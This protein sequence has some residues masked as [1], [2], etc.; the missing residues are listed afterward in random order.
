MPPN[1]YKS[2]WTPEITEWCR[3]L[4]FKGGMF[5]A[6]IAAEL[7]PGFNKNQVI[8]KIHRMGW[9]K[10]PDSPY[11]R[12]WGIKDIR[13]RQSAPRPKRNGGAVISALKSIDKSPPKPKWSPKMP[14]ADAPKF[15]ITEPVELTMDDIVSPLEQRVTIWELTD[16]T[17]RWPYGSAETEIFFCGALP[18][19]GLPYC[20]DHCR[21]AYQVPR[22]R[23]QRRVDA[24]RAARMRA[25]KG[26][27]EAA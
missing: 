27:T 12:K 19:E 3:A 18:I 21:M 26:K 5:T 13:E 25:A 10:H 17:C 9:N 8:G 4:Y 7:G 24:E 16:K 2:P 14:P 22:S 23:E 15:D 1:Q 6:Q 11:P 20:P